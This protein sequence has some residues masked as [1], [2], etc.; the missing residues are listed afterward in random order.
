MY[1]GKID[2][3]DKQF[4]E[5]TVLNYEGNQ[6][7]KCKCSCG[8]IKNVESYFLT[9]GKSKSC[10]HNNPNAHIN[11]DRTF[12]DL[13]D[14]QFGEWKVLKYL[15]NRQWECQCS[16]GKVKSVHGYSLISGKSTSCGHKHLVDIIEQRKAYI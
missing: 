7:F 8:C 16:C 3:T 13:T 6:K 9:S 10:G 5:W 11:I 2:L 1:K 14:K 4:G 12:K 15:G